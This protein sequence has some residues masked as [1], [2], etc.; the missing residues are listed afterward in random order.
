MHTNY[1]DGSRWVEESTESAAP[2]P[3]SS[4]RQLTRRAASGALIATLALGLIA[5]PALAGKPSGGGGGTGGGGGKHGGGST[6]TSATVTV[7]PNPVPAN[8]QFQAVG[9]GYPA[10]AGVQLNLYTSQFTA[11]YGGKVDASGCLYNAWLSAGGPSSAKLDVLLNSTTL[12]ATTTFTI[13]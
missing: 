11:V 3:Q 9:C 10:N 6:T 12:V 1:W 8:S 4:L 13:Q 2:A 7:A 5:S